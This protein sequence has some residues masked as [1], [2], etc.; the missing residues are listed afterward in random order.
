MRNLLRVLA[1]RV[2]DVWDA[3]RRIAELTDKVAKLTDD[4]DWA[5]N[6]I[7]TLK[8]EVDAIDAVAAQEVERM[9]W[10]GISDHDNDDDAHGGVGD[11]VDVNDF[12]D[13]KGAVQELQANRVTPEDF[14]ALGERLDAAG[15]PAVL[16]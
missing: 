16:P 10:G 12:E 2:A 1:T 8:D 3:P 7:E 5:E 15:I 11:R 14:E 6:M 9:I 4:L 13:V